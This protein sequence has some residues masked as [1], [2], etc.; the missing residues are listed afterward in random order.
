[1]LLGLAAATL[2]LP[3]CASIIS[4]STD[5]IEVAT[6]P[7]G[8]DCILYRDGKNVGRINPTP[9]KLTVARSYND[10][11]VNCNKENFDEGAATAGSGFNGWVIGNLLLG[12]AW[13][14]SSSTRQQLTPQATMT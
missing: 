10:I 3:G 1:M 14:A 2:I 11:T 5:E 13:S 6:N 7:P 12:E 4:G 8:A 9:G